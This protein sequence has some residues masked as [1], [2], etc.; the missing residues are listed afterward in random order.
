MGRGDLTLLDTGTQAVSPDVDITLRVGLSPDTDI[1]LDDLQLP[2]VGV[3]T[4]ITLGELPPEDATAP[5]V[6][7]LID[8][9]P[10]PAVSAGVDIT[11]LDVSGTD[12]VLLD[13]AA[14]PPPPYEFYVFTGAATQAPAAATAN[15]IGV[16]ATATTGTIVATGDGASVGAEVFLAGVSATA[17]VGVIDATG[18]AETVL[19]GV[20]AAFALGEISAASEEAHRS[21]RNTRFIPYREGAAS[22]RGVAAEGAAGV[23]C[24]VGGGIPPVV[25]VG[26]MVRLAGVQATSVVGRAAPAAGAGSIIRGVFCGTEAAP[27]RGLGGARATPVWT[28][29]AE[30]FVGDIRARGICN[31]TDEELALVALLLTRNN[32]SRTMRS[33]H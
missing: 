30:A 32:T 2:A 5:T 33:N 21:R 18:G 27:L 25:G 6:V 12:I 16:S 13:S 11:L 8:E 22:I 4:T 19:V 10:A 1:Q 15:L 26:T 24:A 9:P 31:P 28:E 17:G 7:T 14:Q 29:E 3:T 20:E 23:V